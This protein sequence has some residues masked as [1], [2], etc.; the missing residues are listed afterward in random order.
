MQLATIAAVAPNCK[1]ELFRTLFHLEN[2]YV[3]NIFDTNS[4]AFS[5]LSQAAAER[6][7]CDLN[8]TIADVPTH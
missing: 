5:L 8:L 1:L 7:R 6:G 2:D 4:F 3:S